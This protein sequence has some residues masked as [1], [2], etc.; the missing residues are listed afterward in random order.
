M[1][2]TTLML[3]KIT[4]VEL[5][6]PQRFSIGERMYQIKSISEQDDTTATIRIWPPLR[7]FVGSGA[8]LEFDRPVL[9]VRLA[10]DQEMD[11]PLEFGR[12]S[13]PSVNFIEDL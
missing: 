8:E 13:F 5:E 6:P 2:A 4:P 9:R 1:R 12:W 10:T 11:L 3:T 7:D